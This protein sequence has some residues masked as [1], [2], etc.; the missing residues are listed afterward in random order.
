MV[1]ELAIP[2]TDDLVG[3]ASPGARIDDSNMGVQYTFHGG[4]PVEGDLAGTWTEW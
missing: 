3:S 2:T 1:I 4:A